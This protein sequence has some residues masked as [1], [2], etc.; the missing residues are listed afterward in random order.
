[1]RHVKGAD[2]KLQSTMPPET[3]ECVETVIRQSERTPPDGA[4]TLT[5]PAKG[6][7]AKKR[8]D[9][10]KGGLPGIGG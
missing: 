7:R 10:P 1:M 4:A 2:V 8:D 9:G 3:G 6:K 5:A